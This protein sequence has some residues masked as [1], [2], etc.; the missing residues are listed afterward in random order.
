VSNLRGKVLY[1]GERYG[2]FAYHIPLAPGKYR[3][4]LHFAETWFGTLESHQP[5]AGNRLFD[6]FANGV[7]LLRGYEVA[8]QAGGIYRGV[9]EVFDD[10]EPNAQGVL[11]LEFVPLKNYAEV[12]AIEVVET[13]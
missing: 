3:L 5:A 13:K 7:A 4:T 8:K 12:N 10:V 2:N 6:V 1:Q 9:D 11:V